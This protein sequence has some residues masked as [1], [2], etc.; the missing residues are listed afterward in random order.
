MDER[1][2][3]LEHLALQLKHKDSANTA[4][5]IPTELPLGRQALEARN[6]TE[7]TLAQQVLKNTGVPIPGKNAS[8]GKRE[9]FLN[10]ILNEAYPEFDGNPNLRLT[11]DG[12]DGIG[13]YYNPNFGSIGINDTLHK[14]DPVKAVATALHE[15]GHKYDDQVLGFTPEKRILE[16]GKSQLDFK[17]MYD[18]A[19]NIDVDIDPTELYETAAKGHHARIPG[20]RDA[21]SFGLGALKSYLKSGTFKSVA[22]VL[23]KAGLA[24]AGGLASLASEAADAPEA[25]NVV[26][27]D[28][29]EREIAER[30]RRDAAMKAL[31]GQTEGLQ[32]FYDEMD[33]GKAFDPRIDAL[34][35]VSGK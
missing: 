7:E 32:Q 6:L 20:L 13:G 2:K 14:D 35:K 31:S 30:K 24:T 29:L 21:D 10:R 17:K 22:P 8:S 1:R 15:A 19:K 26:E 12:V 33:S 18:T 34:K 27:Q 4:K 23:A 3:A 5:F 9:D 25:G 16:A 11:S 28:A